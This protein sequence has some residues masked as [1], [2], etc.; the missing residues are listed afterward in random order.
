MLTPSVSGILIS[1][2]ILIAMLFSEYLLSTHP[3][4]KRIGNKR[5]KAT[6]RDIL[7]SL[8]T[9]VPFS[10][11]GARLYHAVNYWNYYTNNPLEILKTW[12]GGMGFYGALLGGIL[13][14]LVFSFI[15]RAPVFKFRFIVIS[16]FLFLSLP[17][18]YAIGRWESFI[19]RDIVGIPTK[20]PWAI[21]VPFAF[22]PQGFKLYDSFH[23]VFLYESFLCLL[24]FLGLYFVFRFVKRWKA[25][26][27]ISLLFLLGYSLIRLVTE[28]MRIGIWK[29]GIYPT[30][31]II[32]I[33]ILIVSIILLVKM[34]HH[35][36]AKFFRKRIRATSL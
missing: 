4:E 33:T 16:D 32:S 25:D 21:S 26:G 1:I 18:A 22:R 20:V 7:R 5:L 36:F 19:T 8:I 27:S 17:L 2:G 35:H 6:D 11:V 15:K 24:L 12:N 23:P 31:S 30:A 13:A 10:L 34:Y 14:F 29:I 9:I 28:S 3:Q